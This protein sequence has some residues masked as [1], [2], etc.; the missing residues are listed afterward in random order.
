MFKII[1]LEDPQ[2]ILLTGTHFIEE[3]SGDIANNV[4]LKQECEVLEVVSC[5]KEY[6][7][8][9][10]L[11]NE[12]DVNYKSWTL[13]NNGFIDIQIRGIPAKRFIKLLNKEEQSGT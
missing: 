6:L 11:V 8:K 10:M 13:K 3:L 1:N 12:A 5:K 7:I 9:R 2:L 4:C